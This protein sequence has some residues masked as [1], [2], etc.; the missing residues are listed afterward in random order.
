VSVCGKSEL[1][2][3]KRRS[4]LYGFD[5][6]EYMA[7]VCKACGEIFWFED[8]VTQMEKRAKELAI[9]DLSIRQKSR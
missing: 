9:W 7:E 8:D 3:E 6:G 5:L 1:I 4:E 2:L